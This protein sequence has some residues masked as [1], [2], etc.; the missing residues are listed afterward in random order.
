MPGA[1]QECDLLIVGGGPAGVAAAHAARERDCSAIIIE[2]GAQPEP[3]LCGGWLGPAAVRFCMDHGLTAR[4]IGAREFAGV[5]LMSWDFKHQVDVDDPEL[6]GWIVDPPTFAEHWLASAAAAGVDVIRSAEL[7]SLQLGESDALAEL[8]T[9]VTICGQIVAIADGAASRTAQH[10]NLLPAAR[11]QNHGHCMVATFHTASERK[12]LDVVLA[13]GRKQRLA[14]LAWSPDQV[15]VTLLTRE[16]DAP[17]EEQM[18]SLIAAAHAAGVLGDLAEPTL[19][20]G[21]SLAGAA[22]ELDSH[23]GKRC[24]LIGAAG[25]FNAAFNNEGGFPALRS[26]QLAAETVARALAAPVLQDELTTFGPA[27]RAD[28]ADYLR[29]PNTDLGL[30]M[31]MLFNNPQMSRRVAHAFLLGRSI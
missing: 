21:P 18:R 31:P 30:L 7:V 5:H 16:Q 14:T 1:S 28:L 25:G 15:R 4:R 29:M 24:L 3:G 10:A 8:S 19:A 9:G 6:T 26:G 23:V 27:W 12:G 13:G 11:Q 22:L 2:R 17:P 20:Q